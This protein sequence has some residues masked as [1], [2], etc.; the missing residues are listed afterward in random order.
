MSRLSKCGTCEARHEL[1][2][3]RMLTEGRSDTLPF[4]AGGQEFS[5]PSADLVA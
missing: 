2:C 1:R 5:V 3:A 4:D